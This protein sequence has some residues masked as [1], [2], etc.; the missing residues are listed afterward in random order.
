MAR[1]VSIFLDDLAEYLGLPLPVQGLH[2]L[3][4]QKFLTFLI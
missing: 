3:Q 2:I 1:S 4:Q